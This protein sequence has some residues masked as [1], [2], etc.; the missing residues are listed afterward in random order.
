M[1][2]YLRRKITYNL[3]N[4]GSAPKESH[5]DKEWLPSFRRKVT[6]K[7]TEKAIILDSNGPVM[8]DF[9]YCRLGESEDWLTYEGYRRNE[10][11]EIIHF[12]RFKE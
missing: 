10:Y 1:H 6:Q 12:Y 2:G 4:S 11:D 3:G 5:S 9:E 8:S 7:I